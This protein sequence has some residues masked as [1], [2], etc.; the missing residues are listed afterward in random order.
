MLWKDRILSALLAVTIGAAVT[1]AVWYFAPEKPLFTPGQIESGITYEAVGVASDET[2]VSIDGNTASA[3]LYTFWLGNECMNLQSYYGIDVAS[4]WDTEI[5]EGKTLKDFVS[6]D[7]LT[8]IRQQLVLENLC[9]QYGVELTAEDE[10]ELAERRASYVE[11]FG[12]EDG[13]RAELYKLGISEEGY[14]R[15]SR[16]DYLYSRLYDAYTTPGTELYATD[17]VLRAYA[18]GAGYITAD[19]ILLMTVDPQTGGKLDDDTVEQKRQQ[20]EDLLWQL[21]DSADPDTLFKELADQYSED[22]GRAG[23][24]DGYTFAQGTMVEEFDSAARA[25]EEGEYSDVVESQYGYHII[26]RKP[27]DVEEAVEAVR[28]EYFSVFFLGEIERAEA[29]YGPAVD[30]LD[31]VAIFEALRSAQA[32][33]GQ[34]SA[35]VVEP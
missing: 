33:D 11:Q 16:T 20:A 13:Y 4:N 31:P 19:H 23:Y 14:E 25:L 15:L 26:L 6:E 12:G 22:A 34:D 17:D 7:T 1:A 28:E 27:L 18:V 2:I 5:S 30:Q 3:E 21:R 10:A 8:A 35:A 9:R 24:P 32:A 29:E